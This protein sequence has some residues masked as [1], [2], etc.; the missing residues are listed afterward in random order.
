MYQVY[1]IVDGDTLQSISDRFN[2]LPD[3]ILGLNGVDS[4]YILTGNMIVLPKGYDVYFKYIVKSGDTMSSIASRYGQSVDLLYEING[5]KEDDFIY[6]G[7]ELLIPNF[8]SYITKDD[9]TVFDV[10]N[11]FGISDFDSSFIG[12]LYLVP[13]QLVM[14]ERV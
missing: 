1:E 4:S 10:L 7:Q 8:K 11:F 14:N 13:G 12:N 6:P 2:I 3:E 5:I 9:D